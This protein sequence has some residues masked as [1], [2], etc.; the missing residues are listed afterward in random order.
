MALALPRD[1]SSRV[2]LAI[3]KPITGYDI[4]D[5]LLHITTTF[6]PALHRAGSTKEVVLNSV[7]GS[8]VSL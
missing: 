4:H 5:A 6:I 1:E 8:W 2:A 3:Y 7:N